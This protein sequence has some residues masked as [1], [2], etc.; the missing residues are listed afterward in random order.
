L[1]AEGKR[2]LVPGVLL[3]D[4]Q[5]LFEEAG[6][7]LVFALPEPLRW[8]GVSPERQAERDRLSDAALRAC[9]PSAHLARLEGRVLLE[10]FLGRVAEYGVDMEAAVR[11]PSSFQWGWTKVPVVIKRLH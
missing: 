10:E 4:S 6:A 2:V 11:Q 5:R 1:A 8:P 9:L 7:E 3:G